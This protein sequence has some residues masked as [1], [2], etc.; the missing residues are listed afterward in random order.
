MSI[1]SNYIQFLSE[2]DDIN[3][4]CRDFILQHINRVHDDSINEMIEEYI[5][6]DMFNRFNHIEQN[7]W[8]IIPPEAE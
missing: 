8:H 7:I 6:I 2:Q 4:K 1:I 3:N 5:R